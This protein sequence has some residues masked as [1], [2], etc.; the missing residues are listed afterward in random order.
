MIHWLR[1]AQKSRSWKKNILYLTLILSISFLLSLQIQIL[2]HAQSLI[3]T[4]FVLAVFLISLITQGY[5]WG[6]VSSL[7][8]MMAV[9]Y[10]FTF[11]YFKFNFT[12]PENFFSAVIMLFVTI[13]TSTLTTKIKEQEKMRLESEKEKMR[14]NLLRAISHDLRTPLTTI[15]GSCSAIMENYDL[16]SKEQQLKLLGEVR[17]DSQWLIR[18]VENLLSVTRI[19]GEKVNVIKTPTVLEELIDTVLVKFQKRYPNQVVTIDIPDEFIS[20][21]MDAVLIE[22][23]LMNLLENAVQHAKG[24]KQLTLKVFTSGTKAIF[25]VTDDGCGIPK[26]QM[27][28]LFTAYLEKR[29][30]PADGQK[31][32]MG[33]GLSVC[34]AILKAHGGDIYAKNQKLGGV[35]F[36]FSLEKEEMDEENYE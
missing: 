13:V 11:P 25:E 14:A 22:Q 8:S 29:N 34:A 5:I 23:V 10:A 32:N 28:H 21:P 3:P 19:D 16:L 36:G 27:P 12:M 35:T 20:I 24:M 6:I 4:I 15:Y 26:E 17:E 1:S 31:N 7:I 18:M 2:F 30:I 33:I 9:N